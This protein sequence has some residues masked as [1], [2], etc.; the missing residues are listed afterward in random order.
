MV[1]QSLGGSGLNLTTSDP[2]E[3]S[4][5][6]TFISSTQ[7]K[8]LGLGEL[9][10]T[11]RKRERKTT[12]TTYLCY[13]TTPLPTHAPICSP[14]S[15]RR[16][17]HTARPRSENFSWPRFFWGDSRMAADIKS[18]GTLIAWNSEISPMDFAQNRTPG[19]DR[20]VCFE[21]GPLVVAKLLPASPL[22]GR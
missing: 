20:E 1:L 16:H 3:S 6:M 10:H 14:G 19:D 13:I 4:S 12:P 11:H 7:P 15:H 2:G 21:G 5:L 17:T 18:P 8:G 22:K 9:K